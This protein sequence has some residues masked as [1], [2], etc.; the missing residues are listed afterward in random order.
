[1]KINVALVLRLEEEVVREFDNEEGLTDCTEYLEKLQEENLNFFEKY[2]IQVALTLKDGEY[3]KNDYVG[4][5]FYIE[6]IDEAGWELNT[7]SD[8]FI[9]INEQ[10]EIP[11][12][13]E[14]M[15]NDWSCLENHFNN[16]YEMVRAVLYGD[17]RLDDN[18]V[19]FNGYGNLESCNEIPYQDFEQEIFEQWLTENL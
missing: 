6:K 7:L 5:V 19:K 4:D 8:M 3:I 11:A 16:S 1:M 18:F 9:N 13:W 10:D 17:Y 15:N 12:I 2:R 14:Y